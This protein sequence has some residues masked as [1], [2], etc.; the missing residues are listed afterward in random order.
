MPAN[1]KQLASGMFYEELEPGT[2]YKH[3]ITRT[4]TEADNLLFSTLT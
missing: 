1:Y 3:S 4:V 2:V